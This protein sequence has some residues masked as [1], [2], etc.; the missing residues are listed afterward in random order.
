VLDRIDLTA[1]Q[2]AAIAEMQ[3]R[4]RSEQMKLIGAMELIIRQAHARDIDGGWVVSADGLA[5]VPARPPIA[6]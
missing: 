3:I 4:I 2:V 6:E 1:E 5:L